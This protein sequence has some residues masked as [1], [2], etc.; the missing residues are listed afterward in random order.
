VRPGFDLD[1]RPGYKT[2]ASGSQT[3]L[4]LAAIVPYRLGFTA[5][6]HITQLCKTYKESRLRGCIRRKKKPQKNSGVAVCIRINSACAENR[7]ATKAKAKILLRFRAVLNHYELENSIS[8]FVK[9]GDGLVLMVLAYK[10]SPDEETRN[11]RGPI[12]DS[13]NYIR[14]S[15]AICLSKKPDLFIFRPGLILKLSFRAFAS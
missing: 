9:N 4:C 8:G 15:R 2:L 12:Y 7:S 13:Q 10:C 6:F 14:F 5:F 11:P 3:P 1:N